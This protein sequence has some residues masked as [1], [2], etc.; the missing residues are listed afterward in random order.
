MEEKLVK[1]QNFET[2]RLM[3]KLAIRMSLLN[4]EVDNLGNI[5]I[6]GLEVIE[7]GQVI[8][9]IFID[10]LNK[11]GIGLDVIQGE[12]SVLVFEKNKKSAKI[13]IE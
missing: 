6:N 4:P 13:V 10:S 11:V 7:N 8:G 12:R 9:K 3:E 5:T 2:K 1:K